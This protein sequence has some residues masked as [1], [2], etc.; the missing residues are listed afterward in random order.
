MSPV[1]KSAADDRAAGG[2]GGQDG[3][4]S[5]GGGH[6]QPAAI[7]TRGR[8]GARRR[9]DALTGAI[10]R[11]VFDELARTS[12]EELSFDKIAPAAGTGKAAL[13]RRWST[14]AELVMAALT[15][16][17][18]GFGE[19][20]APP[21]T[22]TLR[23]D[24]IALLA[25]LAGSLGEPRGRALRPLIAQ[26]RRH[27]G[28]FDEVRRRVIEPHQEL[29]RSVLRDAVGRGEAR[30]G[31][32]TMRIASVGPRLIVMESWE[33]DH[34]DADEVAAIVDEILIPLVS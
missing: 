33:R 1:T 4:G 29:V 14:P 10:Y 12:F 32:D 7:P 11:A 18:T 15:D 16:P 28:L 3:Q 5:A 2:G 20:P 9:G 6:D 23:G 21:G 8:G 25:G 30:P 27:P 24:L 13:Y 34:I 26:R 19:V 17:A 22:G 31:S